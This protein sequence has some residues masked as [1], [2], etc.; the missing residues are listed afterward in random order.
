[1]NRA[2]DYIEPVVGWRTW[3]V[4]ELDR[5]LRLRS[6]MFEEFWA[7]GRPFAAECRNRPHPV[8]RLLRR[9]PEAAHQS[10]CPSCSCGIYAAKS[11]SEA[12]R[13]IASYGPR[14]RY[15]R[16]RVLG[17]VS[18]WGAVVEYTE[19]WRAS[20]AY[21]LEVFVPRFA[22]LGSPG[23]DAVALELA[24]YGVK[25]EIVESDDIDELM[26]S[27]SAAPELRAAA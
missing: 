11:L 2:P 7:P 21:P 6:V 20:R 13:Y 1:M 3:S 16:H 22:P 26:F 23:A 4:S 8:R 10:P 15:V 24:D 27:V 5:R 25:V 14:R 9:G 17:R 12:A 19:G 18:L